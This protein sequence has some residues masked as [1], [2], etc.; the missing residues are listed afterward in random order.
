MDFLRDRSVPAEDEARG[1]V[2]TLSVVS[3]TPH[4]T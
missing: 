1:A 4:R 2:F 3:N